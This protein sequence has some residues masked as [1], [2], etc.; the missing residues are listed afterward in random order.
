[1]DSNLDILLRNNTGNK[2]KA[3]L[4]EGFVVRLSAYKSVFS[5]IKLSKNNHPAKSHL[6]IGQRGAGKTTLLYRLKYAIEDDVELRRHIIPIM[7]NEEQYHITELLNL[8]ENVADCL[9]EIAGFDHIS[10]SVEASLFG[11]EHD[12]GRAFKVIEASLKANKKR[13]VLFIENIDVFLKKIGIEEQFRFLEILET[14]TVFSLIGSATTYFES[15]SADS[16][17]FY[18]FFNI[19]QL[20]GLNRLE[21]IKLL[22]KLGELT[23]QSDQIHNILNKNPKRIE[24]LRRLTGGNP[25]TMS[26]LFQIFLDNGNGKAILDLYKLLDDLT[27]LYKAELDQLSPQQQKVIDVIARNWDAISAKEIAATTKIDSKHIS[28]VLNA[29]EKNQTIE[30]VNTR[31]NNNLYRIKD[32]FLN[33]WYLM[34]FGRKRDKEN[35]VWLVR[36]YDAWC[37][38]TELSEHVAAYIKNLKTGNYDSLAAL[39]M[40]NTFLSCINVSPDLKYDL[41]RISKS[42][43]PKDMIEELKVSREVF[44]NRIKSLVQLGDFDKAIDALNEIEPK[45]LHYHTFAY[46]V[47][48]K[49]KDYKKAVEFLQLVFEHKQDSITAFTIADIYD[50]RISDLKSAIEYYKI[51]LEKGEYEAAYRLGQISFFSLHNIDDA[52]KYHTIA[53]ENNFEVSILAMAK[54]YF[55]VKRYDEATVLCELAIEKGDIS[56]MNN[57]AGI[58]QEQGQE[59]EA[60]EL[61]TRAVELGDNFA[62]T[63][64]AKAH[65]NPEYYDESAAKKLFIKAVDVGAP[66]SYYNLGMFLIVTEKDPKEGVKYLKL[67]ISHK[68]AESAHY[69][70]H[71]YQKKNAYDKAEKMFL[72]AFNLGR[73]SALLCLADSAFAFQRTDRRKFIIDLFQKHYIDQQITGPTIL[74]EYSRMLLW[75]DQIEDAMK[76]LTEAQ[77]MIED[78]FGDDDEDFKQHLIGGL[79]EYFV[80]LIAKKKYA[81]AKDIFNSE[82]INYKQILKPVYY[83]LMNFMK[84]EFP[85]EYLKAG[86]ELQETIEEIIFEIGKI[87]EIEKSSK[88]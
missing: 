83:A 3:V 43:L 48:F 88:K 46:W 23:N 6:I 47:Y 73:Q 71:Y 64:L 38:K 60:M 35:I 14:T 31:I 32:R 41:W 85:N 1:M 28:S 13:A 25:R 9:D 68:E 74:L 51:A 77:P 15:I 12:E 79:T 52:I 86:S 67:G 37:N 29:L 84:N 8:W 53:I 75:D 54:I 26:Y 63:N 7:F 4:L 18:K 24:S 72:E 36:F 11:D 70:A 61:L 42:Y 76:Y 40:G 59:A 66:E 87:T 49:M 30:I 44:Y 27:F 45:D 21:S 17:P 33:I 34:R 78:A 50:R 65:L 20:N 56:A 39:D 62:I 10:S 5:E 16:Q 57:L 19:I 2:A 58:K 81:L 69:L 80:L 55:D 82:V 22:V